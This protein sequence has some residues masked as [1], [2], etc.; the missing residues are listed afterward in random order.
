MLKNT[1]EAWC[2]AWGAY[3]TGNPELPDYIAKHI[4]LATEKPLSEREFSPRKATKGTYGVNWKKVQSPEYRASLEKLSESNKVVNSIEIRAKWAL[5]NRNGLN[6]EE[7]YAISLDT[8]EE[9][10]SVLGQQIEFG[11][12]RTELFIRR[13]SKA[14]KNREKVLLL[15]NHPR[16]FPPS[17]GDINTLVANKN[18]SGITVGHDGSIY[19]YSR[20]SR[21]IPENDFRVALMRYSRYT[22]ITGFEKALEDLS[23]EFGFGFRKL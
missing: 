7:L 6:T 4:E 1:K 17:I 15:H 5:N 21:V 3:H 13:L 10:A 11:V 19:Y 8:G 12:Q 16:G 18:V 14:D 22:E 2:E 9:I 23:K 20:P